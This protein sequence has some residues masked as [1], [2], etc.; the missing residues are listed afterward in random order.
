MINNKQPNTTN[1]QGDTVMKTVVKVTM[2]ALFMLLANVNVYAVEVNQN[3]S[4]QSMSECT[5]Y[6]HPTAQELCMEMV[7]LAN[8]MEEFPVRMELTKKKFKN[9]Q[10]DAAEILSAIDSHLKITKLATHSNPTVRKIFEKK[11]GRFNLGKELVKYKQ[12]SNKLLQIVEEEMRIA[13]DDVEILPELKVIHD[14]I[15]TQ[16]K[17]VEKMEAK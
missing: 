14:G 6:K 13:K 1:T 3:T 9:A 12:K 8:Q 5:Q 7:D 2:T 15:K 16:I 17:I 4:Q 10:D 11:Y